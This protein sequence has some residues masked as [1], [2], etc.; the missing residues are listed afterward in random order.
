MMFFGQLQVVVGGARGRS[1]DWLDLAA[2]DAAGV[3]EGVERC[4]LAGEERLGAREADDGRG[5]DAVRDARAA[6]AVAGHGQ[7]DGGGEGG[8][9]QIFA[10][11]VSRMMPMRTRVMISSGCRSNL[12]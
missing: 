10:A 3:L 8:D 12:R 5:D 11:S 1:L 2:S 9:V 4:G 7:A 6:D